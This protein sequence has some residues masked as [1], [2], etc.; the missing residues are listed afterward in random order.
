M[1]FVDSYKEKKQVDLRPPQPT[2]VCSIQCQDA[3]EEREGQEEQENGPLVL[4]EAT[5]A[6]G[7]M[8]DGGYDEL[9]VELVSG[10][11]WKLI[12]E[13]CGAEEATKLRRSARLN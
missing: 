12:E 10:L 5:Y 9:D 11:T 2:C 6:Q 4:N 7:W 8:V 13:A 3:W 1:H